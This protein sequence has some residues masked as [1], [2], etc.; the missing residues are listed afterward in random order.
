M[1]TIL[2]VN[3]GVNLGMGLKSW[4]KNKAEKFAEKICHRNSLRNSLANFW[5][6]PVQ[7][8]QFTPNP[9]CRASGSK[10]G[11][12]T[13]PPPKNRNPP[14]TRNFMGMGV[15]QQKERK[16]PDARKIGAAI[17][18]PRIAGGK[19]LDIKVFLPRKGEKAENRGLIPSSLVG[20]LM[21]FLWAHS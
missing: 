11:T 13:T 18:G 10:I 2:G 4:K 5:N 1:L 16:I 20:A 12:S 21:V 3:L 8:K 14:K 9:L 17:S 19:I 7:N 6:L 15:I